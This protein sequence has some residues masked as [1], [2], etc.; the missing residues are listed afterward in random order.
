MLWPDHC[1]QGTE[2]SQFHREIV[3]ALEAKRAKGGQVHIIQKVNNCYFSS[4]LLHLAAATEPLFFFLI[5]LL[6]CYSGTESPD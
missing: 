5:L 4:F 3:E 6:P 2:G 1:I